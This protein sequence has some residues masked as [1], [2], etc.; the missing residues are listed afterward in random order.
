MRRHL[1]VTL[2]AA[3]LA[4]PQPASAVLLRGMG[5]ENC[6]S[7]LK[8]K[9]GPDSIAYREWFL[10]YLS[11]TAYLRNQDILRDLSY[12]QLLARVTT[13]CQRAPNRRLDSVLDDFFTR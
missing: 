11:A 4:A 2:L 10:G 7:W 9:D 13:A 1:A 8:D 12:A 6:E 3:V 5:V